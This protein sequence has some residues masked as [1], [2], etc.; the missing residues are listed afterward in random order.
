MGQRPP[1]E[2]L[3]DLQ[4]IRGARQAAASGTAAVSKEEIEALIVERL[5][6]RKSKNFA[7]SDE[8]RKDLLARGVILKDGP[9]GTTWEYGNIH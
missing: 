5:E 3:K 2:A 7:R 8:I 1:G 6:S 9:G 4:R